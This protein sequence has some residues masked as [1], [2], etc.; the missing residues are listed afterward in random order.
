MV[1]IKK[2]KCVY[3]FCKKDVEE[4]KVIERMFYFMYGILLKDE[5]RKYCSEVC[6]EKDQ[7]VYEF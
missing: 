6:V 4:S 1:M 7:M 3:Y 5:L 2:I